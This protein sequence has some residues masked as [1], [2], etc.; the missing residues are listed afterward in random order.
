MSEELTEEQ[1]RLRVAVLNGL[2][3]LTDE[4]LPHMILKVEQHGE[5]YAAGK[6]KQA[7][8]LFEEA[9]NILNKQWGEGIAKANVEHL[10]DELLAAIKRINEQSNKERNN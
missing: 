10:T 1:L 5:I 2:K 3:R 7:F 8:G 9:S 4:F 6:M